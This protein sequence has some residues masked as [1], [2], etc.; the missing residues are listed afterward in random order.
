MVRLHIAFDGTDNVN[1]VVA[2]FRFF[3]RRRNFFN[4]AFAEHFG[5]GTADVIEI[6]VVSLAVATARYINRCH[7]APWF[8]HMH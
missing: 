8:R 1:A 7:S 2:R 3:R 6:F 5:N 4:L